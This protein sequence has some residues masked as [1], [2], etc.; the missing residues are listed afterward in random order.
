MPAFCTELIPVRSGATK[1]ALL[2]N[3]HSFIQAVSGS[4]RSIDTSNSKARFGV[5]HFQA[6][7]KLES[8]ILKP[9]KIYNE[10]G[11]QD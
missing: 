6:L 3:E 1:I 4:M 8:F 11:H 9:L 7:A 2:D 10:H 5:H